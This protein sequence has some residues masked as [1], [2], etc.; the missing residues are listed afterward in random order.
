VF[1]AM[2]AITLFNAAYL[3]E[4]VRGGLQSIPSGQV[5]A[6]K[7]LGLNSLQITLD[8]TLPQ[9]IRAIFPALVGMAISTFKDT[10]LVTI[11]GLLDLTGTA[12][13]IVTQTEFIGLRRETLF[14]ITV[15][16]FVISYAIA[17]VS[18]RIE[19][20]GAGAVRMRNI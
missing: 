6:A 11:V 13:N 17:E 5:E 18:R 7:A 8:I 12:Q 19:M 4:N 10:S 9:A 14:F 16:Y 2:I 1:R 15:I 20:S 3:A